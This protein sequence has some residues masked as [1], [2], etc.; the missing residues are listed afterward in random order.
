MSKAINLFYRKSRFDII[1][2]LRG[3]TPPS[4]GLVIGLLV[5]CAIVALLGDTPPTAA[6]LKTP[7]PHTPTPPI[8]KKAWIECAPSAPNPD[9]QKHP[10]Q[11]KEPSQG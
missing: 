9:T 3:D 2:A 5:Y 4:A 7:P 10:T 8:E 1:V 6:P 11:K